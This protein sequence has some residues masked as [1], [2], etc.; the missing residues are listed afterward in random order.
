M[1]KIF[2]VYLQA[3]GFPNQSSECVFE[4][5]REQ[6]G[7]YGMSLSYSSPN[8]DFV[9]F[10]VY[11]D[12]HRAVGVYFLQKFDVCIFYP[13]FMKRGQY[14]LSLQDKFYYYG[15]DAIYPHYMVFPFP[16][17]EKAYSCSAVVCLTMA[18]A[19]L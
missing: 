12:C 1:T 5:C 18:V 7:R 6:L 13:L 19:A 11:V 15:D 16:D 8:V 17:Y 14:C 9:A 4:C 10:F 3:S 2:A